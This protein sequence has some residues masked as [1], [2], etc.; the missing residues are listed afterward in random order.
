[1]LYIIYEFTPGECFLFASSTETPNGQHSLTL[2]SQAQLNSKHSVVIQF[3]IL[4]IELI[5]VLYKYTM[6]WKVCLQVNGKVTACK[7]Q[8]APLLRFNGWL[9]YS[10]WHWLIL[11]CYQETPKPHFIQLPNSI[12]VLTLLDASKIIS[13]RHINR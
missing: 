12:V 6:Q 11:E 4:P 10:L 2:A 8:V 3:D 1:M 7:W 5:C 9:P 13:K